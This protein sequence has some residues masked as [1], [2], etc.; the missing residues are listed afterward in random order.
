MKGHRER[1]MLFHK[2][3][4]GTLD[5]SSVG[6]AYLLL[7]QLGAKFFSFTDKWAIF[8]PAFATVPD[9]WHR[10][11]SD[12]EAGTEDYDQ[13]L[14]TPRMIIDSKNSTVTRV[15]LDKEEEQ[16]DLQ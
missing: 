7:S 8:D 11:A 15:F 9:H 3:H 1:L 6:E 14:K 5:E 16:S 13:I 4:L 12:L 10:I 2:K